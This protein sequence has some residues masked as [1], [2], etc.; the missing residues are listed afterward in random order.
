MTTITLLRRH[1][2]YSWMFCLVASMCLSSAAAQAVVAGRF[3]RIDGM[4]AVLD[5][6]GTQRPAVT[7]ATVG[8]G[9]RVETQAGATAHVALADGGLL[10]VRPDSTVAVLQYRTQAKPDDAA[11]LSL[12]RGALRMVTGWLGKTQP[13]AVLIT[14]STATLGIRG[15]DFEL[16]DNVQGSHVHVVSG[17]VLMGNASGE[18][19]IRGG[20][21]ASLLRGGE[22]PKLLQRG[23]G[24]AFDE[25][26]GAF[27]NSRGAGRFEDLVAAHAN[28]I[29]KHI[30]VSL[31][32]RGLLRPGESVKDFVER[33]RA[34]VDTLRRRGEL[35]SRDELL[36]RMQDRRD[37]ETDGKAKA[38]TNDRPV[39]PV[40]REK[41]ERLRLKN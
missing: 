23:Q 28:G 37:S 41:I 1:S 38:P 2:L 27:G 32:E 15:T 36:E 26:Q 31:R 11:S 10:V 13:R 34:D 40:L 3:E 18:V 16:M 8:A 6:A 29:E 39:R 19:S 30:E 24:G 9:E 35:P 25:L 7:G 4:V 17:E 33:R 22:R 5:A 21:I 14:T 12:L 20:E